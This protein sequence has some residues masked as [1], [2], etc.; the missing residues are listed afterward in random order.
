MVD[1]LNAR[2]NL[3][4]RLWWL[5]L[6]H[7]QANFVRYIPKTLTTLNRSIDGN[8]YDDNMFGIHIELDASCERKPILEL[9]VDRLS[10]DVE[11]G[12]N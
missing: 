12:S 3:I 10:I 6:Q 5:S 1:S 11:M 9:C 7:L 4:I 2:E 8:A